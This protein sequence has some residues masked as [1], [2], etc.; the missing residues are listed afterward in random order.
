MNQ[1]E[2]FVAKFGGTSMARPDV[3]VDIV[4][5]RDD[6]DVVVVSAPGKTE[7]Y[8]EKMTDQLKLLA[9]YAI[10]DAQDFAS[11][12]ILTNS[13][14]DRFEN[15][16]SEVGEEKLAKL[17]DIARFYFSQIAVQP[18]AEDFA[19]S[20]GEELSAQYFNELLI[21]HGV[22][23][24]YIDPKEWVVFS[25]DGKLDR[26]QCASKLAII[27]EAAKANNQKIVTP[28]FYGYDSVGTRHL[29][30]RGGSDRTGALA[31]LALAK[32]YG[33]ENVVYE[34]WTDQDGIKTSD[35]RVVAGTYVI[36]ELTR[37][38]VREGAN[39]GSGVLQGDTI[40]D[41]GKS[42]I[43]VVVRN[44]LNTSHPGTVIL[45]E[46]ESKIDRP[47]VAISGKKLI[48]LTVD[49]MGMAEQRGYLES[50]LAVVR[51]AHISI[52]HVPTAHDAFSITFSH[53]L[54]DEQ[55][56][57]LLSKIQTVTLPYGSDDNEAEV[58]IE[59]SAVVYLVGEPLRDP[60][61]R[62]NIFGRTCELLREKG[63]LSPIN[64]HTSPAIALL[65]NRD[66]LNSYMQML[67]DEF[68]ASEL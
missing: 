68:I 15:I 30:G 7:V 22:E 14:I 57:E 67:H 44:T 39:G 17:R 8:T 41:L 20:L 55:E 31:A 50:V 51:D 52:E 38:E 9:A 63:F 34:N 64:H 11:F 49:H 19:M 32:L 66:D 1:V 35:P 46:R 45:N 47:V 21:S 10:G 36:S 65:V 29:L 28:G 58:S 27:A 33:D 16:Y 43:R 61:I 59:Q 24:I 53:D 23:S 5:M 18:N 56:A 25:M 3:V 26:K 4:A 42:T 40:I 62:T 60:I 2:H 37:K 6:I 54:S 13:L 48:V 12:N